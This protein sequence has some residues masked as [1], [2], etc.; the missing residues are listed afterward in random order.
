MIYLIR[1]CERIMTQI[2]IKPLGFL[3]AGYKKCDIEV[4]S[5][6]LHYQKFNL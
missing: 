5:Y 3:Y 4:T 2:V 6:L 1:K